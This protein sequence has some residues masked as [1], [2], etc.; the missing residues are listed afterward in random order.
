MN[1]TQ[2]QQAFSN[3]INHTLHASSDALAL[4]GRVLLATMFLLA[5]FDKIAGFS[6]TA[7]Y[8]ASVGLPL[9]ELLTAL[10]IVV[11]LGAGAALLVGYQARV[12]ALLLAG[13]TLV[14]SVL[15]H[16]YWAMPAEQAYVQQLMFMKNLAIAG[17]LL[18]VTALGAG[19]WAIQNR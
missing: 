17:G 1:S 16:K 3:T 5:G 2:T 14:A 7:G 4:V 10:T 18:M 8:I 15:F 12:A 13:F 19:K 11:E 6:G 9:P